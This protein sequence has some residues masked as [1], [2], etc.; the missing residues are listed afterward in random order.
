MDTPLNI[1]VVED[2]HALREVTIEAL[3]SIGHCVQGVECA[4]ELDEKM[5]AHPLDLLVVD[6]NLPGE[7]GISL[8]RRVRASQPDVTIIMVTARGKLEDRL[9]GY[10]NGADIYLTKPTSMEEL[11]AAVQ[12]L[13]RRIRR[14]RS[15]APFVFDL[16]SRKLRGPAATVVL[17]ATESVL[18]S[19]F[20]RAYGHQLEY[21]QLMEVSGKSEDSFSKGALEVQI[22]RLR[23]KLVE[24]G[25]EQQPVKSVRGHGYQ[26]CVKVH[27]A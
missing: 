2:H 15:D 23:K 27:V 8:A 20:A 3:H 5:A 7:D 17:S 24:A 10:E 11:L 14:N 19:A 1:L 22:V 18:L 12:A 9:I 26:L 13:S 6:L 4:E 21:W 16:V 25:A